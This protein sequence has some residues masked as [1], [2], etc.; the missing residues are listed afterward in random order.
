MFCGI[1]MCDG[2]PGL[3]VP[4]HGAV[5]QPLPVMFEHDFVRSSSTMPSQSSSL[6][7]Q[8]S[9]GGGLG[10]V[11]VHAVY[12]PPT[13]DCVPQHAGFGEHA[14]PGMLLHCRAGMSSSTMVSQSLSLPS[15]NSACGV[16][17]VQPSSTPPSQSLSRPSL[18]VSVLS[19]LHVLP[20]GHVVCG[21]P[22]GL[23]MLHCTPVPS[24]LHT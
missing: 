23:V 12:E 10:T 11:A 8:V 3:L 13:Q 15:Q 20:T 1:G 24:A 5:A 2:S 14:A 4:G 7:L 21:L 22:P 19:G 6:L 18:Q 9:A 17:V 16:H